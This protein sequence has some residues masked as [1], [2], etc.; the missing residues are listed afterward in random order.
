MRVTVCELP[1]EAAALAAAWD[2]LCAHT[3][4]HASE[5]VLLPELAMAEPVWTSRHFAAGRWSAAVAAGEE[6]LRRLPE[7]GAERVVGTR[8]VR[9][10]TRC[11]NQGFLWSADAG[12]APLRSKRFMPQERGTWEAA[13]FDGGDDDFPVYRAGAAA[14][15][16]SICTELWALETLVAYSESGVDLVLSPRATQADTFAT[17]LSLGIVAAM[18][19]GAF[20][21]SSN[22]VDPTGSCGGGGWIIDPSG[23]ILAV[24]SADEPFVTRDL[25]L[26]SAAAAKGTYPRYV[27]APADGEPLARPRGASHGTP[28]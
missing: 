19:S 10:G 20:S 4:A 18:R 14:F 23:R 13:W 26:A 3:A 22:R 16:L 5:L 12:V 2:A 24:T 9:A 21:V 15:G 25:D 6:A 8:A 7:L 27:F 28:R 17:W 11:L 1:H